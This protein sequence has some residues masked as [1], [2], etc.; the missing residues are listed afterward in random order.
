ME[1]V[2]AFF[3]LDALI[4]NLLELWQNLFPKSIHQRR[5]PSEKPFIHRDAIHH[6]YFCVDWRKINDVFVPLF[7][8]AVLKKILRSP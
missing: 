1:K 6:N 7:V 2:L 5:D 4:L 3:V 8:M